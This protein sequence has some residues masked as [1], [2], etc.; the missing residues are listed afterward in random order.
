M[1]HIVTSFI[2]VYVIGRLVPALL[3][4]V[5]AKWLF[6]LFLLLVSQQH[7]VTKTF[8]GTLASPELPFPVL[9]VLGWLFGAL[10]LLFGFLLL[11]DAGTLLLFVFGKLLGQ[12]LIPGVSATVWTT[13]FLASAF[14]LAALGVWQAVRVPDVRS[15]EITLDRLP[16]ELDGLHVV[17]LSDLHASRL[18]R[19]AWLRAVVDKT[20]ALSPDLILITGDLV[21]GTP[22]N[23]AADVAPLHDLKARL[24]VLAIPGNH[25]Y[26]SNFTAWMTAFDRLGLRV[27]RNEHVV[28]TE[29]GRSLVVAGTTDRNAERF[30]LPVPDIGAA[31]AGAPREAVTL[32]MAH[33]P[34]GAAGN[35]AAGVDLQLSGHTHGGQIA[36]MHYI[37]RAANEGFVSGLY[38]V[39]SMQL[40]VSNGTGLW[41]GLPVRLGRPS[42]ITDIVLRSP[43]AM[44]QRGDVAH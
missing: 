12:R 43:A 41:N 17:Q 38:R 1:I 44:K 25:E 3:W 34:K 11:K 16:A 10:L 40:Y 13:L 30:G 2:G 28:L 35:A 33:Q 27:L 19:G 9:A 22:A 20:N 42:E 39:G 6:A 24:G 5:E 23:R 8:F 37:V 36:G 7:L 15:V 21:D 26:Y 18:L 14:G 29:H 32:L 4:P 31:L